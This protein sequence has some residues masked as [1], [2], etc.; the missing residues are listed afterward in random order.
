MSSVSDYIRRRYGMS[1]DEYDGINEMTRFRVVCDKTLTASI[2]NGKLHLN[3]NWWASLDSDQR[4]A[5]LRHEYRH[6]KGKRIPLGNHII[7]THGYQPR[8]EISNLIGRKCEC[9]AKHTSFPNIHSDWCPEW[10]NS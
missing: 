10:R 5:V 3:E 8:D 7:M 9:G 6:M 2:I 4:I 1:I